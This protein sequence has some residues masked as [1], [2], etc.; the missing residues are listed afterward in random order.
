MLIT[1]KDFLLEKYIKDNIIFTDE[2]TDSY[3]GQTNHILKAFDKITKEY[4]GYLEYSIYENT[5][6][7]QYLNVIK[8]R[9]GIGT[10]LMKELQNMYP[11]I[12]IELGM[13]TDDGSNLM[14]TIS[15]K[16]IEDDTYKK[17]YE[18]K[19]LIEEEISKLQN[20]YDNW[21]KL[22]SVEQDELRNTDYN[23]LHDRLYVLNSELEDLKPGKYLIE[24][25]DSDPTYLNDFNNIVSQFKDVAKI[26]Y[27]Y[28]GDNKINLSL[29]RIKKKLKISGLGTQILNKFCETADKYGIELNL[30]ATDIYGSDLERLMNFYKKFGFEYVVNDEDNKMIRQSK[31]I[32][33]S[34]IVNGIE[35]NLEN[36]IKDLENLE[37]EYKDKA[38]LTFNF[39][40]N[41]SVYLAIIKVFEK[42]KG[43]GTEIMNKLCAIADKYDLIIT[44]SPTS[45]YGSNINRL[46]N[47]YK[48]FGFILNKGRKKDFR[49]FESM[50]RPAKSGR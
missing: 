8:Q 25:L 38:S 41:F 22:S 47:F 33:E 13:L 9:Q 48:S 11:G 14:K 23:D 28:Q 5:P 50:Y 27:E 4:L 49:F 3:S 40:Q 6:S 1:I 24:K 34:L 19:L 15:R 30:F 17:K 42:R 44:C 10:F 39:R 35:I 45:E 2:I 46:I 31:N 7:V 12:E 20:K 16:F 43:L 32:N 26:I 36:A 18:E 37:K 21:D 29:I